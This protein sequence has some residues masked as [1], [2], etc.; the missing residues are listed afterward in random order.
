MTDHDV[1]TW[2]ALEFGSAELG[3]QRRTQRL[4][5]IAARAAE[6]PAGKITEVFKN[7]AEREAAFRLVENDK[8][9]PADVSLA[10]R[11]ACASRAAEFS[12]VFVP[13]DGSSLNLTDRKQQKRLGV[14]G[15]RNI[16]AQGMEVMS[17]LAIS[18]EGVPLGICGQEFWTRPKRVGRGRK[19]DRHFNDKET[20]YWLTVMEQVR[21]AMSTLAPKTLPWFQLDRYGDAW[22]VL[23][24]GVEPGHLFTVRANHNRRLWESSGKSRRYLWEEVECAPVL[25]YY[26]LSVAGGPCR[27]ARNAKMEVRATEVTL[28]LEQA[29]TRRHC[30]ATL[31]AV[32]TREVSQVP[33]GEKAIEW[34]L[35]TTY[36]TRTFE[37]ARL[38]IQGYAQRWR[39]E[40][41]HRIWKTG[42]CNVEDT[43][44]G[45]RDHI[46]RWAMVLASVAV[47]VLRINYLG[48]NQP[49]V[50]ASVEFERNEIDAV[51]LLRRPKGQRRGAMPT[52]GQV[53]RWLADIGG[54]TGKS[55]GAPPGAIVIGR[56]LDRIQPVVQVLSNGEM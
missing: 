44:L 38:V 52:V 14:V 49:D 10:A 33:A 1:G 22:P 6:Q 56:G 53:V 27:K 46:V 41:F 19:D 55:S 4:V 36:E 16:G 47:R 15:A 17:A 37:D 43:Q 8:V 25:G 24:E 9:D 48:R 5:G 31:F 42:R 21:S 28:R 32:V 7:G 30:P 3:D 2:A 54:Y 11:R 12:F 26:S 18:P 35:L 45:D 29:P 13:V 34:L 23:L 20:R 50:P 39:I 40:E 51:I